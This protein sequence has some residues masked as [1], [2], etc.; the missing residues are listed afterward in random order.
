VSRGEVREGVPLVIS[1]GGYGRQ[2]DGRLT[3]VSW[4]LHV[5]P[6]HRADG[7]SMLD[8]AASL[9]C[10]RGVP[11]HMPSPRALPSVAD[12]VGAFRAAGCHGTAW[13]RVADPDAGLPECPSASTCA[14]TGGR[15]LGE[16]SLHVGG[17]I[18]GDHPLQAG[19]AVEGVSFRKPSGVAVLHAVCAL[20]A[21]AGPLLVCDDSGDTAFVAW[22]QER[23]EDLAG[24][25]PW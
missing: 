21:V 12:V 14:T 10:S 18:S 8:W 11:D 20:A 5:L 23:A 1:P 16:V 7:E 13:F 2:A 17:R 22:P 15:D 25:W 24:E 19:A 3:G 4:S 9:G 6:L